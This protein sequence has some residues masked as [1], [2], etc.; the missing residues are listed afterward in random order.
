M[1]I[2]IKRIGYTMDSLTREELD[3]V[4]MIYIPK[5]SQ[6]IEF[7]A[8]DKQISEL[9]KMKEYNWEFPSTHAGKWL[10]RWA[11]RLAK[12]SRV[13]EVIL[14]LTDDDED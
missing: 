13:K 10:K 7:V 11:K 12:F 8:T 1:Q 2:L 4:Y 9:L 14:Q 6:H 3:D 5:T